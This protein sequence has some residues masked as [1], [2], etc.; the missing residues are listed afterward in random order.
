MFTKDRNVYI[1]DEYERFKVLS[2]NRDVKDG[3]VKSIKESI[4]EIGLMCS[5]IIVNKLYEIIDGQNR[6][7]AC[8]QLGLPIYFVIEENAGLRECR[9]MNQHQNNWKTKDFIDSYAATGNITYVYLKQLIAEFY[10]SLTYEVIYRAAIEV[11]DRASFGKRSPQYVIIENKMSIDEDKYNRIRENLQKCVS[12]ASVTGPVSQTKY[13]YALRIVIK[14]SLYPVDS[15]IEKVKKYKAY[16]VPVANTEQ[17]MG[18]FEKCINTRAREK[19]YL[20]LEY[21]KH[22]EL[23]KKKNLKSYARSKK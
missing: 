19:T 10:P 16:I 13:C 4:S 23:T 20:V 22:D 12:L 14:Y 17:A 18:V 2:G 3:G 8:K 11:A 15:L 1:T 6:F 5:P 9:R 7:T 21:K